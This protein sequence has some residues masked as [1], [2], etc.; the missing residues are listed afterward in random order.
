[1]QP[2]LMAPQR[3]SMPY[4]RFFTE[5]RDVPDD[6][7]GLKTVDVDFVA[8]TLP[9]TRDGPTH[10][11]STWLEVTRQ[12]CRNRPQDYPQ[13]LLDGYEAAYAA[14]KRKEAPPID[15]MP[16]KSWPALTP[17]Q[18]KRCV[19]A[20]VFTVEG[21][22]DANAQTLAMIGMGAQT[23]QNAAR[24]YFAEMQS[25]GAILRQDA[26][27]AGQ[28]QHGDRAG[29]AGGA[30]RGG[31]RTTCGGGRA[32]AASRQ[33]QAQP[34]RLIMS[35][36][37]LMQTVCDELGLQRPTSGI[38]GTADQQTRQMAAQLTYTAREMLRVHD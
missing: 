5:S 29:G 24:A 21:L 17:S 31:G 35:L 6:A 1:M 10:E 30:A 34:G 33:G 20:N 12:N 26:G 13:A 7:G 3:V 27:H 9:G 4:C 28:A 36:L 23:L 2:G 14:Y 25:S 8:I 18:I 38:V 11:V 15:G 22:R 32:G 37:S 16:I 19:D